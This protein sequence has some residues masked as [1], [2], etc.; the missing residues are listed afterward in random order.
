MY[1]KCHLKE[2]PHE[3]QTPLDQESYFYLLQDLS[4]ETKLLI[5]KWA[6]FQSYIL[7]IGNLNDDLKY[8]KK[9]R[10]PKKW[11]QQHSKRK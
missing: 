1:R 11:S 4:L 9:W 7:Q 6:V 2:I 8:M 5:L 3:Q 10:F